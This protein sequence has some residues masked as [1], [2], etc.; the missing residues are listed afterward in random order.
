MIDSEQR[1][2]FSMDSPLRLSIA[3]G[4]VLATRRLQVPLRSST[5]ADA[6]AMKGCPNKLSPGRRC[7][8]HGFSFVWEPGAKP[9][10]KPP[11]RKSYQPS[12]SSTGVE[13]E[14]YGGRPQPVAGQRQDA[15]EIISYITEVAL[16]PGPI[17]HR[18]KAQNKPHKKKAARAEA[19]PLQSAD[20]VLGNSDDTSSKGDTP[21]LVIQ[22]H[23]TKG[24]GCYPPP[25]NSAQDT[26]MGH[27]AG[28]NAKIGRVYTGD[29]GGSGELM[30]S[31]RSLSWRHDVSTPQRPQS[32]GVAEQAVRRTLE[33]SRSLLLQPGLL[34]PFWCCAAQAFCALRII[35]DNVGGRRTPYYLR[36]GHDFSGHLVFCSRSDYK[37]GGEE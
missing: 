33:G 26:K 17:R 32:T 10:L 28:G 11:D 30:A 37:L 22:D 13:S 8:E 27:F 6:L 21:A 16:P 23:A 20:F 15:A 36:H 35:S 14:S 34:H 7:M 29:T 2:D 24:V 9:I 12:S 4:E 5:S 19:G 1:H 3:N 18:A 31:A 25:T